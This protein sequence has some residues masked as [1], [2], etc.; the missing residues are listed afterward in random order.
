[1][2]RSS[3]QYL[4]P[5]LQRVDWKEFKTSRGIEHSVLEPLL[6]P[7]RKVLSPQESP[8]GELSSARL[9][10][11]SHSSAFGTRH[12]PDKLLSQ[13]YKAKKVQNVCPPIAP[14]YEMTDPVCITCLLNGVAVPTLLAWTFSSCPMGCTQ[15]VGLRSLALFARLALSWHMKSKNPHDDVPLANGTAFLTANQPYMQ[16][17]KIAKENKVEST[18]NDHRAVN[19]ANKDWQHLIA[20]GIGAT[21]CAQHGV[22][23]LGAIVDFQ[24]GEH[25]VNM[26]YSL[27]QAL[28]LLAGINSVIVL[29][30][31][32][33]QYSKHFLKRVLE[34]PYLQVSSGV[35][36]YKGIRLFH[37]HGHQDICF[38]RYAPKFIPK[39]RQVDVPALCKKFKKVQQG[40]PSSKIAFKNINSTADSKDTEARIA[41]EKKAQQNQ[42]HKEDTMNI[43]EQ[44]K[45][46]AAFIATGNKKWS[47]LRNCCLVIS[48]SE[49]G[50]D[51]DTAANPNSNEDNNAKD[52]NLFDLSGSFDGG[53]EPIERRK[54]VLPS[55]LG[56]G[57]CKIEG[58]HHL[59]SQELT[60]REGQA[61]YTL[62]QICIL[63]G[64]KFFLFRMKVRAA[65]GS[66]SEKKL[67]A[68]AEVTHMEANIKVHSAIYKRA[69]HVTISLGCWAEIFKKYQELKPD[70][71]RIS[72]QLMNP[73]ATGLHNTALPWFW[74]MDL[75][76]DTSQQT[77]IFESYQVH[78]LR[79]K[80]MYNRWIEEDILVCLK[81]KRMWNQFSEQAEDLFQ[82]LGIVV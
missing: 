32:M 61:N 8:S 2:G 13:L 45:N 53:N 44:S 9:W 10:L 29:Y 12:G 79:A 58:L 49:V 78:W 42:L 38:P 47:G 64:Q 27:C 11:S 40:L 69:Q 21:A 30:N 36:I 60:L 23:C 18:C 15:Q 6:I 55:N 50:R 37:V 80:A 25:Q 65:W 68:W 51:S 46:S 71:L 1:M 28:S 22:F 19:L 33:C 24:K 81:V 26:D 4:D 34:G 43:Y 7:P 75:K 5:V 74:S 63:L 35:S 52:I 72:T 66:L 82:R 73:N 59:V 17:L 76:G 39:A 70:Y 62:H 14:L 77:C 67:K 16:H 54:L 41:Q 20:T 48:G 3:S 31:I 57:T 56:K